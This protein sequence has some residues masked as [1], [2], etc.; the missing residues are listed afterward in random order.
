MTVKL[1]NSPE[2]WG[3]VGPKGP[4][5]VSWQRCLD[6]ISMAGYRYLELGPYGYLPTNPSILG[7]ELDARDLSIAA[8]GALIDL[9]ED[10]IWPK[11]ESDVLKT[12]EL[13]ADV[14][15]KFFMVIDGFYRY[16]TGEQISSK[17]LD[18]NSW[19]VLVDTTNK[20]GETVRSKFDLQLLF[21]PCADTHVE[22]EFQ[23]ERLLRDTDTGL[24]KLCLDTG[25]HEYRFGDS[26]RFM[27]KHKDRIGY[28]H[29]KSVSA[30]LREKV[31]NE[32]IAFLDA[33]KMGVACEPFDG[34]VDFRSLG[35]VLEQ[36]GYDGFAIVEQDT[37]MPDLETLLSVATRTRQ[38]HIDNGVVR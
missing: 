11:V 13:L 16:E 38:Y 24:V 37:Y 2:S 31:N 26:V 17:E 5:Q 29:L 30:K 15:A 8:G 25:H 35:D 14:G 27:R 22:Y 36:I 12:C 21:H 10:S 32:N 6:E 1:G 18:Q 23:I 20:I 3:V 9:S 33:V 4:S 19:N 34:V 28:L 7:M